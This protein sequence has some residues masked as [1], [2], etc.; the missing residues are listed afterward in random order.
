MPA[1]STSRDLVIA[2]S[3]CGALEPSPHV[4][5]QAWRGGGWGVLDLAD[6]GWRAMRAL[7]Q[8]AGWPATPV[9]VRVPAGCAATAD[10]VRACTGS[11][12]ALTVLTADAPWDIASTA[13]WSR[14][15]VEVTSRDEARAAA[16]GGASGV[17]ARGTESGG[18]VS[19]LSTFVLL[20][21]L[22]ADDELT[23]P[24]WAAGGI[25]ARTAAG[26]VTGG[27]AGVLLDTQ[28]ALLP[29]S[30]LPGD[31]CRVLRRLDGSETVLD[32]G[33]RGI[34]VTGTP[35]R[36]A[37][38]RDRGTALLPIGQDG[39]LAAGFAARWADTAAAV[40]GVRA[41]IMAAA[42]G[43]PEPYPLAAG[44]ALADDLGVRIPVA[45]GP[46][47][48]VSDQACFAAAVAAAGAMPFIALALADGERSRQLLADTAAALQGQPWGVGVL[49]FAPEEL[50]AAQFQAI[51]DITPSWAIVAGGRP[52]Q[53]KELEQAG[54][55]TFLHVPSPGL[56]RQFL[57]SGVRRFV[58][59][60]AECG[61]HIGPRAS[62]PLWEAQLEVLGSYLD[63]TPQAAGQLQVLFA[64]GIHD[65]R[66]AAMVAAMA[67][68]LARRGARIGV[69]MGT[70][71]LFTREAVE[72]GAILPLFQELAVAA[73][74]TAL[75]ETAPGHVTRALR[76]PYVAEFAR[77]AAGLAAA[78]RPS[79]DIWVELELLNTGRLRLASKGLQHDGASIDEATQQAEG[80]YM[81]GQVAV[82]RDA[83][84]TVAELH[85]GV[86]SGAAAFHAS[87]AAELTS[88]LAAAPAGG[89]CAAEDSEP[90]ES[91]DIAIIGMAAMFAG[92]AD[93]AGF[94]QLIL[95]G[96]DAFAEVPADRWD[97]Q[98]YYSPDL[99]AGQSG[100]RTVSKW[101]GFLA[102]AVIDPIRYGIPPS[103]LGSIDPSQLLALEV[104]N[105]ALSD[106]GHPYDAPGARHA[107]T[108]VVFAA[109]PGSDN[110][111]ALAMR[112]LLP[113]YL[114]EV[115]P[116]FDAQ[117]PRFTEDTFPGN[118]PNVIAGRIA[119]R[120]DLGGANFTVDAAC[121]ASL[122]AVDVSCKQLT[123]G[124]ADMML[125][126]AV[127]LH[128]SI[129]DFLMFG[130]VFALSPVGRVAT[131]DR[132][133]DGTVL[134]EGVA[135]VVLKRLADAE[136]DGDR[137]YA[138]IRGIGAASDG[139]ARS[140]TAPR[141]EG[142]VRAM[143]RAYRQAGISPAEVELVEAHG[144]GTVLGDQVELQSLT[145]VFTSAGA[146]P[147]SCVLGSVKSQIGHAKCAA[148]LAGLIK[149]VLAVHCGVQPATS[150]LASPNEAWD[151]DRSP[152]A[153]LREPRPWVA[154]P[155]RRIAGLSAFGFGG[156]NFHAVL[157]GYAG[158]PEPRH[159]LTHWPAELF[160]LR[161]TD[162]EAAH[163]AVTALA[164][165]VIAAAR[166]PGGVPLRQLA[167]RAA[168]D[169]EAAAGPVRV[170]LVARDLDD[171][172]TL[173][174][175]AL[176]GEHD[177]AAGLIQPAADQDLAAG[178]GRRPGVAYLFPGQG[179]QRTGA[180]GELF[181]AFPELRQYLEIGARWAGR[182]F[183]PAAFDT[184]REREQSDALRDTA[185]AQ[186]VLGICGLAVSHL[187][188]RLGVQ[189]DFSGGHSYGELVALATAGA[190]GSQELLD[191]SEAR[192]AAILSAAGDDPGTM[193]AVSG[194]AGQV[195]AVLDGS[196]LSGEVTLANLNA[197][198][199]VVLSGLTPAVGRAL[200]ALKEAG[201]SARR[202]PVACA[203]HSPVVAGASA[204]FAEVLARYPVSPPRL[205]VWSNR[206]ARPHAADPGQIRAEMAAQISAPVQFSDQ[207][208]AMYEAGARIFIETGPGHVLTGLVRAVLGDRPHLAVACDGGQQD[209]L[210][211]FLIT[212]GQLACAGLPL[213]HSWL[214]QGR[215]PASAAASPDARPRWLANGQLIRDLNGASP[216]G[217]LTPAHP[218]KEFAVSS[219]EVSAHQPV[220][221]DSALA[222]YLR[223]SREMVSAHR[224]VMLAFLGQPAGSRPAWQD[225]E[226][227]LAGN[228]SLHS[229]AVA[230]VEPAAV[231][232]LAV[233]PEAA[234]GPAS[235][236][237]AEPA[238]TAPPAGLAAAAA[239][240]AAALSGPMLQDTLISLISERTGY[241]ADLIEPQLD[242]EAD[243]SID[244]IKR[245]E[246]AAEVASRLG[247]SVEA[248]ES[249]FEGLVKQRTVQAIIGWLDEMRQGGPA[250]EPAA[251]GSAA[252][253]SAAGELTGA[254]L[255]AGPAAA[256][257]TAGPAAELV[258]GLP[259]A[260][261][262]R[263]LPRLVSCPLPAAAESTTAGPDVISGARFVIT[264]DTAVA[265]ELAS[266]LRD[267]GAE[268]QAT[269]ASAVTAEDLAGA[270]GLIMLDGLGEPPDALPPLLF[271]LVQQA[272]TSP[273]PAAGGPGRLLA[274]GA[275]GCGQAAGL[276]GLF[277]A[278]STEYPDRTARYVQLDVTGP[279]SAVAARLL[280]ELADTS[281]EPAVLYAGDGRYSTELVAAELAAGPG[282]GLP[283]A[284]PGQA[285]ARWMGLNSDS[286]VV[287]IGG[288]RGITACLARELAAASG[289]RLELVGRTELTAAE[290]LAA[291]LAAAP[292]AVALR[293]AL[294][295]RGM[296]APAE[297]ER[298]S[299][300]ILAR[301]EVEATLAELR[302]LGARARYHCADVLD[303]EAIGQVL[304][305][306]HEEHGRLDGLVFGAGIIEDRLI[307]EKDPES[308]AR[309]FRTK[310]SGAQTVLSALAEREYA[311]GF[312]VLYGSI[313][314]AFGSRGQADYAAAN[315]AL[316]AAG[317][318]WA[319][320]T[321]RRCLTVHWGPWAPAGPH[322]G[323]VSPEL[324]REYARRGIVMIDPGQ[325]A[326]SLLREL[327]WGDPGLTAVT[328]A[329]S[330]PDAR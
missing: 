97:P 96:A 301:R 151:A 100:R 311:P 105:Q 192:A 102:P 182:L 74:E 29:E 247:I 223:A 92:S 63:E 290:P 298:A 222:E 28:L 123:T 226:E 150:N 228:G 268:A 152:F 5:A 237:T 54:I 306:V 136:R 283:S 270:A 322:P 277:R 216:P 171:L 185:T 312:V 189:P 94:W 284:G 155:G 38:P 104:A 60:G 95:S 201:L 195:S 181:V 112:A 227:A 2:I 53:A 309:V 120:L 122:A 9:G 176:A 90:S 204:Q 217:A 149:A 276:A 158:T 240:P 180:L 70:S 88:R 162:R 138:I 183:P 206:T 187:L 135:C 168:A 160:C 142:Q 52:A 218:I 103:A 114:G 213:E 279:A 41:A 246:I 144:T 15:L 199:Q 163:R 245:A 224:D 93:L 87:R 324:A 197:P 273:G 242:L 200:A 194:T 121:A 319:A 159:A 133:A 51:L 143:R 126:G 229:S 266:L 212:A 205:P 175:R 264:G 26:C 78:G 198:D 220:G 91:A 131:F 86:T 85:A 255:T 18:R 269:T 304:K 156:T 253:G 19:D 267:R 265:A 23:V 58:F 73:Q 30:D 35:V 140:L 243:L 196:G 258:A 148:G 330:V 57:R 274:V 39:C 303:E 83:V 34:R 261:P 132:A 49:G 72:H 251:G 299:R 107:R 281:R 288:A 257:L 285:E 45:Q 326:S 119:N 234:A 33:V 300:A 169:A 318:A 256:A 71:Y 254:A 191:L 179:S 317:A 111:G 31:L 211:R 184:A 8:A 202:L 225:N 139:R 147:G 124:A 262:L 307:A 231:P 230:L 43:Q 89:A 314:A 287:L 315:D 248:D 252:G 278:V 36:L 48:R 188:G 232:G 110:S 293:A 165:E 7:A 99:L 77:Q 292:D 153:F 145:E 208:E 125:C 84:T 250:A 296:R 249:V 174:R 67:A 239:D 316:E 233:L 42:A 259:P 209:T 323:M 79:R 101:G 66:S 50:R 130:S 4:A 166:Q 241:P 244:S 32:D 172:A 167:A 235:A 80:L 61:G 56:L 170:A 76:T 280:A 117:L 98:I 24:V 1:E 275:A 190:F 14:V 116:E 55:A 137:I 59:E 291:E 106:S 215:Q 40:R 22:L 27:A 37:T 10:Q 109:E 62:F 128:N 207:I 108:G 310:V 157:T 219:A 173:L 129:G 164:T 177:P 272:L 329:G 193:A 3:P 305:L 47:T 154:P 46:M 260:S 134:G 282:P 321:G 178:H 44:A 327:A 289:C 146:Q 313:A 12:I 20:Q 186:P 115:P 64:G 68:D 118:L 320:A 295:D 325:G 65:A 75:L 69:L 25:G 127:D 161:G 81:A 203:F 286:V 263:L 113:A 6:G 82:L 302:E 13:A 236:S 308:F 328:Y 17:I 11:Q 214:F 210:R 141:V 297:I 271:P 16:A 294:A 221:P 21:Q 238:V